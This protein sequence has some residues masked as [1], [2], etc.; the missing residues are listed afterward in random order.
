MTSSELLHEQWR[1]L[2]QVA[3]HGAVYDSPERQPHP[4]CLKGT[5]G[6]LLKYIYGLSDNPQKSQLIWLHGTAGVGKSAVAFTVAERMRDLKASEKTT[7]EKRLAGTFFFSRTTRNRSTAAYVFATLAYQLVRNF[8][9]VRSEVSKAI[10]DNPAVLEPNSS[11]R[12]QMEVLFLLPLRKFHHRLRG[13]PPLLFVIDALDECT[14]SEA[15]LA[16]LISLLGKAL[17]EPDLPKL[18]ILLTSRSEAHIPVKTSGDSVAAII[19]LDGADVN[20]DICIFLEHSFTILRRRRP[21]FPLL[22]REQLVQLATRAGRRFIVAS[23]MVKFVDDGYNDP[24]ARLQIMLDLTS[25]LLPGTEVYRLYDSILSTCANPNRAFIHLSVVAALADP[26]PASQI[27]KLLGPGQ[28]QDVEATLVQLRSV[29]D[30]PTDS[31]L[32]VNI[33]H[34][35][36]RDYVSNPSN[37]GL[38]N[39][40][41]IPPTPYSLI[42]RY[43]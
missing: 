20:N 9:S 26:L 2:S 35:S 22:T 13:C 28:G 37:C 29:M 7:V 43:S 27:S 36:V 39:L 32:P 4:K 6:D 3:V 25:Q 1:K 24:R 41:Y 21:D 30:V 33:Y 11:F 5:R 34:S 16:E 42:P 15:E 10:I 14:S 17:R 18:H 38:P 40:Q 8:P 31:S 23:T 19:S 12:D